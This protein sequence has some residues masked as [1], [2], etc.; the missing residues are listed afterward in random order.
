MRTGAF[1]P[2]PAF[3][4]D[5]RYSANS[6]GIY[7]VDATLVD[8]DG[9]EI[10][11]RGNLDKK[12]NATVEGSVEDISAEFGPQIMP[13]DLT[14]HS[15]R[16]TGDELDFDISTRRN[17]KIRGKIESLTHKPEITFTADID[18]N[19]PWAL[20]WCREI[21]G[22]ARAPRSADRSGKSFLRHVRSLR[23]NTHTKCTPIP[24]RSI[25]L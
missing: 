25:S 19:E 4:A 12:L 22:Q 2:L 9:G 3:D 17:S 11:L 24:S 10:N 13:L 5:I 6:R 18:E 16:K 8:D 21:S 15:A 14:I 7:T 20:D 1:W 23:W